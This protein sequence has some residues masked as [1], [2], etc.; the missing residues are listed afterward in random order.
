MPEKYQGYTNDLSDDEIR[1]RFQQHY[2]KPPLK[3]IRLTIAMA[4]PIPGTEGTEGE[5]NETAH[6]PR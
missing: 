5:E 2:G 4:G 6:D 3:I 1:R